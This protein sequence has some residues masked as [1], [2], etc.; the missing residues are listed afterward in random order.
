MPKSRVAQRKILSPYDRKRI[1][2]SSSSSSSS[3]AKKGNDKE[4]KRSL[5]LKVQASGKDT[6]WTQNSATRTTHGRYGAY[7]AHNTKWVADPET[8]AVVVVADP[9]L[10]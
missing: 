6:C 10:R 7:K 8:E 2:K 9:R 4:G 5:T 1:G 3:S